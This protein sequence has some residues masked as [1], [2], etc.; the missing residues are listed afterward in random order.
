MKE[1]KMKRTEKKSQC[2]KGKINDGKY[3]RD[4]ERENYKS[5][6]RDKQIERRE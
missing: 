6:K 1:R 2:K 4:I 3:K 5:S